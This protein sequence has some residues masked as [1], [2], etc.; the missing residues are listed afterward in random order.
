M[1]YIPDWLTES[2]NARCPG[3]LETDRAL[4]PKAVKTRPLVLR[5]EDWI[6]EHV[7]GFAKQGGYFFAIS[8]YAI[9][10]PRY[11][12]AEVCC[13]ECVKKWKKEAR[14]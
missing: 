11:R 13:S 5:L 6:D 1:L 12:R 14:S 4:A 3:F 2:L 10:D 9:R 7:F 8:Y